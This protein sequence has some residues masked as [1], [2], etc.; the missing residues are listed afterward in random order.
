MFIDK[1]SKALIKYLSTHNPSNVDGKNVYLLSS[2]AAVLNQK[3]KV[4]KTDNHS[5]NTSDN[6]EI[7]NKDEVSSY[8]RVYPYLVKLKDDGYIISYE[9]QGKSFVKISLAVK[10]E[11]WRDYRRHLF[12]HDIAIPAIVSLVVALSAAL[13]TQAI[14]SSDEKEPEYQIHQESNYGT[15]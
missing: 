14:Q 5:D 12:L 8:D 4:H 15:G 2:L 1:N 3:Q 6:S 7:S 11:F 9:F 10:L 13:F